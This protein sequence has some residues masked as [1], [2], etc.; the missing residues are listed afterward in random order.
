MEI[1][2]AILADLVREARS[3]YLNVPEHTRG[4]APT[5]AAVVLME[6]LSDDLR[7][8]GEA[9]HTRIGL[10]QLWERIAGHEEW[11]S[12]N[13]QN[14]K[15]SLSKV[16]D[17]VGT[18]LERYAYEA[19]FSGEKCRL[20]FGGP[21]WNRR[22]NTENDGSLYLTV[23][24][25]PTK[26][27]A[28]V[29]MHEMREDSLL[30]VRF[31]GVC[32]C[33]GVDGGGFDVDERR[34]HSE[35]CPS[36]ISLSVDQDDQDEDYVA[37]LPEPKLCGPWSRR[38]RPDMF[39]IADGDEE[40]VP[41]RSGGPSVHAP[42]YFPYQKDRL[43]ALG[44][45]LGKPVLMRATTL[46]MMTRCKTALVLDMS[47]Y[48][49]SNTLKDPKSWAV[50]NVALER[51][52]DNLW[53]YTAGN[54]GMSLAKLAAQVNRRS[55]KNLRVFAII[56]EDVSSIVRQTLRA[57]GAEIVYIP[58][59]E[60]H[61]RHR[62]VQQ[63]ARGVKRG[64]VAEPAWDVSE[65]W[66]G[67]GILMYRALMAELLAWVDIDYLVVPIGQGNLFLGAY[68]GRR[69]ALARTT[70]VGAVPFGENVLKNCGE[71]SG[72]ETDTQNLAA[73]AVAPKLFGRYTPFA[74]CICHLRGDSSTIFLQVTR[75]MQRQAHFKG[76]I[77]STFAVEPSA[78]VAFAALRG[79]GQ[80]RGL[81]EEVK[82]SAERP[83][84]RDS[85]VVVV[86]TGLGICNEEE[87]DFLEKLEAREDEDDFG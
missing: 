81:Y 86:N 38:S 84:L 10:P 26:E 13:G 36:N 1:P 45:T 11:K 44:I 72:S 62:H 15:P 46:E 74:R 67:V 34:C 65:G 8:H 76:Q 20:T 7:K 24:C 49:L 14:Y 66:D 39:A 5:V 78:M 40:Y 57:W 47:T 27:K 4:S 63:A 64:G 82:A 53:I 17:R 18:Q 42:A 85:T 33:C 28:L 58:P 2:P 83:K 54:A 31:Y 79:K 21:R 56:E 30:H 60:S 41:L 3:D 61:I 75:K 59:E 22:T 29:R 69:D 16:P 12:H 25:R 55:N 48:A 43:T 50:T 32:F 23:N 77:C 37:L 6:M 19:N 51:G 68:Q 80:A 35:S 71:D 9:G 70:L 87:I 73:N 52:V